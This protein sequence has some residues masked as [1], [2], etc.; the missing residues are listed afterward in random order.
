MPFVVSFDIP[1]KVFEAAIDSVVWEKVKELPQKT[2][3]GY[4]HKFLKSTGYSITFRD[5]AEDL[6]A[7]YHPQHDIHIS[8]TKLSFSELTAVIIHEIFHSVFSQLE[9]ANVLA[10]EKRVMKKLTAAQANKILHAV[11][12]TGKWKF[13]GPLIKNVGATT[14]ES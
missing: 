4:I 11:F 3:L 13:I 14:H 5:C 10:L 1:T 8:S 9:E 12:T 6:G 7:N 2:L